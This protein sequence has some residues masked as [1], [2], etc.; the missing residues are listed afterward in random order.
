MNRH[1]KST[2]LLCILLSALSINA[3]ENLLKNP[4]FENVTVDAKLEHNKANKVAGWTVL[5]YPYEKGQASV[6]TDSHSGKYALSLGVESGDQVNRTLSWTSDAI[7]VKPSENYDLSVFLKTKDLKP[8]TKENFHKPGAMAIF[9]D[10]S[11]KRLK[12]SDLFRVEEETP[13]WKEF[14]KT[15]K[16]PKN[17]KIAEMRIALLLS[18]CKGYVLFDDIKLEKV[19]K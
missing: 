2:A 5:Y 19:R 7:P 17:P 15:F 8:G 16:I 14:S 9:Y 1:K 10:K 4:G 3:G 13:K 18:Y 6:A 11:G 12:H